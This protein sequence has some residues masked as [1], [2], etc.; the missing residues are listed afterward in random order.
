MTFTEAKAHAT[1]E[2]L[3]LEADADAM[4]KYK[5]SWGSAAGVYNVISN[6]KAVGMHSTQPEALA[7]AKK[8]LTDQAD[9]KAAPKLSE[10]EIAALEAKALSMVKQQTWGWQVIENG[11]VLFT[12]TTQAAALKK[13]RRPLTVQS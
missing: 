6:G 13:A 11:Q 9:A 5:N 8:L 3:K 2:Q 10:S 12:Y 4:V 7:A 1:A